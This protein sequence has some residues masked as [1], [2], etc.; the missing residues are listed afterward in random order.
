MNFGLLSAGSDRLAQ[1]GRPGQGST[2]L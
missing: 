2:Y 1:H